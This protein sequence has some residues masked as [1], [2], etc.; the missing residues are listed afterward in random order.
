MVERPD[1]E[2]WVEAYLHAWLTYDPTAIGALFSE[3]AEYRFHPD[4]TPVVGRDAIVESW[5]AERDE[6]GTYH[7]NYAVFAL[8]DDRAAI[9][10]TTTY[11]ADDTHESIVNVYDNCFLV[12]FDDDGACCRFTEWFVER[13]EG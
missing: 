10:G 11:F 1:A 12:E 6:P 5:L 8:E 4:G 3:D 7:A 9:T 2:L 13:S